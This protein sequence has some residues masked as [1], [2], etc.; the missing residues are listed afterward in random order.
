MVGLLRTCFGLCQLRTGVLI[1]S[2][3]DIFFGVYEIVDYGFRVYED[4]LEAHNHVHFHNV[5]H[6]IVGHNSTAMNHTEGTLHVDTTH[7]A[8]YDDSA[9][10][11]IIIGLIDL[12]LFIVL[13][14]V[15]IMRKYNMR[16]VIFIAAIWS[17]VMAFLGVI[18]FGI[19][20]ATGLYIEMF[21]SLGMTVA[22]IV[23]GYIILSYFK[24]VT[25]IVERGLNDMHISYFPNN[26]SQELAEVQMDDAV[27]ERPIMDDQDDFPMRDEY[28]THDDYE[29]RTKGEGMYVI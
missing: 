28:P 7:G 24:Q 9:F 20:I 2:I 27:D 15:T 18:T 14:Y 1:I 23:F 3:V 17:F 11:A 5:S 13:F 22:S 26:Q 6:A 4:L 16:I 12:C 8:L 19:S 29:Y 25:V 21:I 10:A